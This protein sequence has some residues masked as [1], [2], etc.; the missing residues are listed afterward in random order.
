M[1]SILSWIH[2]TRARTTVPKAVQNF[3]AIILYLDYA[4]K[5][6]QNFIT[7]HYKKQGK[8]ILTIYYLHYATSRRTQFGA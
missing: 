7:F 5:I 1:L 6:M 2:T 4:K 3:A 8:L